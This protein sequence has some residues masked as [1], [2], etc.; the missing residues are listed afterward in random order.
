[1]AAGVPEHVVE[2]LVKS[3][4]KEC[5]VAGL[6]LVGA[7]R[8]ADGRAKDTV[9]S[10]DA[11]QFVA[12]V[13]AKSLELS[14]SL[15][16]LL[17]ARKEKDEQAAAA[18]AANASTAYS[19]R[20]DTAEIRADDNWKAEISASSSEGTRV[21]VRCD[22]MD[23]DAINAAL[24][25]SAIVCEV[26]LDSASTGHLSSTVTAI[27]TLAQFSS[28][29]EAAGGRLSIAVKAIAQLDYHFLAGGS[30]LPAHVVQLAL[31]AY[32]CHD[33]AGTPSLPLSVTFS[34]LQ[35]KEEAEY[36]NALLGLIET[37][38]HLKGPIPCLLEVD[39]L[40][41]AFEV[42]EMVHALKSRIIGVG[43]NAR[44]FLANV[45]YHNRTDSTHYADPV[46]AELRLSLISGLLNRV[47]ATSSKRDVPCYGVESL[48]QNDSED[49]QKALGSLLASLSACNIAGVTLSSTALLDTAANGASGEAPAMDP[50]TTAVFARLIDA[51]TFTRDEFEWEIVLATQF[52]AS[53]ILGKGT[54]RVT[55]KSLGREQVLVTSAI[56]RIRWELWSLLH[57]G[58]SIT[59]PDGRA[60]TVDE[61]VYE[62]AVERGIQK[63]EA[64][65]DC[66]VPFNV[67]SKISYDMAVLVLNAL[68]TASVEDAP[69]SLDSVVAKYCLQPFQND[70]MTIEVIERSKEFPWLHKTNVIAGAKV[71]FST[72]DDFAGHDNL[73]KTDFPIFKPKNFGAQGQVYDGWET[74]RHNM[75]PPDYCIVQLAR[76]ATIAGANFDTAH[77]FGNHAVGASVEGLVITQKN[78]R[79]NFEWRTI[80]PQTHLSGN[81]RNFAAATGKEVVTLIK[82][83]NYPDGGI[84]RL[85]LFGD[86]AEESPKPEIQEEQE[87]TEK[88]AWIASLPNVAGFSPSFVPPP[89]SQLDIVPPSKDPPHPDAP[90]PEV[91]VSPLV[92]LA[93]CDGGVIASSSARYSVPSN[94]LKNGRGFNM[95][96]GWETA[97]IRCAPGILFDLD[98]PVKDQFTWTLFELSKPGTVKTIGADTIH[99]KN[100]SPIAFTVEV[101]HR[102]D[103]DGKN[104]FKDDV[105]W[106][107]IIQPA[108]LNA[109]S[110][111]IFQVS[112]EAPATHALLKIFP[113]GGLSRLRLF[114]VPE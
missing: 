25:S 34:K 111:H 84:A 19:D 87:R 65:V 29:K 78:N 59:L 69:A 75:Y 54:V 107:T 4:G 51:P 1:M 8:L 95:G 53:Y 13:Q 39:N 74:R 102:P 47:A 36:C 92:D 79:R 113:C 5:G 45:S 21:R 62:Q 57:N 55:D 71:L 20:A 18:A 110:E 52:L 41:G 17:V 33:K 40:R 3:Y 30:P 72:N 14:P 104:Y 85:M 44:A 114:G 82:V 27:S 12:D 49:S 23:T 73:V 83:N 112:T 28:Q 16:S 66:W 86:P 48:E 109:H 94:M 31:A 6:A 35:S 98:G 77:F 103:L 38:L 70:P 88:L 9:L 81:S 22:P 80:V 7:D 37:L 11:L 63:M 10:T 50:S 97:R 46:S 43:V 67:E 24:H 61:H 96:D 32:H 42:D 26:D 56:E 90:L 76:P 64:E 15:A 101:C 93:G 58:G 68:V 106:T 60:V 105:K 99:N 108:P 100:N 91:I 2:A 89:N